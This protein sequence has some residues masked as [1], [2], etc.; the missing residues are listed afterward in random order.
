MIIELAADACPYEG[1][2]A[3]VLPHRALQDRASIHFVNGSLAELLQ[4][5]RAEEGKDIWICGAASLVH[6]AHRDGLIDE[7]TIFLIPCIMGKG[8][9]LFENFD[10]E[11]KLTLISTRHYK[12]IVD[13]VYR[14][15]EGQ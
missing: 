15:R 3:Y 8:I 6:Q 11:Q 2:T 10:K 5:L 9:R 12:G 14:R 1:K 4:H 13:I 7:I